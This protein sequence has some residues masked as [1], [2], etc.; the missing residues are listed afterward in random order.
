MAKIVAKPKKAVLDAENPITIWFTI[1]EYLEQNARQIG[2]IALAVVVVAGAVLAWSIMRSRA[3]QESVAKFHAAMSVMGQAVDAKT[4][5]QRPAA[6]EK[7]LAQFKEVK[8]QHGGTQS[9]KTALLFAGNCAYNMKKYDEA[10]GYYREF[11]DVAHG[12]LQY[13]RPAGYEG[14]GYAFE[15][16]GD[17]KQAAEWFEKQ[18]Q[19]AE[20][21][22]AMLNLARAL[23][24]GGDKQKACKQYRDF[25]DKNP[26]SGQKQFAQIKADSLCS[27]KGS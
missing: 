9:G 15:G 19:E 21:G 13:L 10:A 24:L 1:R 16:K 8:E 4:G 23:E 17:F 20:G 2:A 22:S 6:Y 5:A 25:I 14:L 7:A 18:A 12:S 3:E 11:L 26:M 27:K